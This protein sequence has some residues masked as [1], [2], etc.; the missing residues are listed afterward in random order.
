MIYLGADHGGFE[1]KEKIK[2][3]LDN[4]GYAYKDM[5]NKILDNEDDYPVFAFAVAEKVAG[6]DDLSLLWKNRPK[7]ILFCRSAGGVVVAANKVKG[8]YAIAVTDVKSAKHSR[9]HNNANVLGLSGDWMTEDEAKEIVKVWLDTEFSG[10]E[11]HLRRIN[12]IKDYEH[13]KN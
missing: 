2:N 1:L 3:Y 7:G 13:E 10:E 8:A 9:L 6:E 12:A 11:R 4:I 5:G